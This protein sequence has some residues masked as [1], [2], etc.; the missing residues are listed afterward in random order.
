LDV[1]PSVLIG[2]LAKAIHAVAL[3][4]I[5]S[6][7]LTRLWKMP[8][9]DREKSDE[10]AVE[11][12]FGETAFLMLAW[13]WMLAP[14]QNPWYWMWTMPFVAF[15]RNPVW[16]WVSGATLLYYL[17]FWFSTLDPSVQ[18]LGSP[19]GGEPFFDRIVVWVEHGILLLT[20]GLFHACRYRKARRTV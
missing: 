13:L 10:K 6:W 7:L 15:A 16:M 4:A 18:L 12:L 14:T 19:Y 3:L 20:L 5:F 2:R 17:R 9:F 1:E 8:F 11:R